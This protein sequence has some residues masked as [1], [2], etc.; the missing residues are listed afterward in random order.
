[1]AIRIPIVSEWDGRGLAKARRDIRQAEGFLGK[2]GA[3]AR[4]FKGT[5]IAAGTVAAGAFAKFSADAVMLASD[6]D[7]TKNKLNE[8]FGTG[9]GSLQ[10][11]LKN[12]ARSL[13][14]TRQQ[15][16]D[17][18]AT[19]GIFG[20]AAGL[21]GDD[22]VTFSEDLVR[23]SADFASFY[24]TSPED[25]ITA[26]GAALRSEAEPIRKY[27][28]LLDAA[29]LK[30]RALALGI[31]EGNEPLTAQQK[32]LAAQAEIF[33]QAGDAAGDFDRTQGGL[34]NSI[35]Q[36]KALFAELQTYFG[37]GLYD[38]L[39][40]NSDGL[41]TMEDS[42]EGL[43]DTALDVGRWFGEALQGFGEAAKDLQVAVEE[44]ENFADTM[45]LLFFPTWKARGALSGT[46]AAAIEA[47][48]AMAKA[49]GD[50]NTLAGALD[51]VTD[52]APK[53]SSA[54]YAAFGQLRKT[55]ASR[56]RREAEKLGSTLGGGGG[57]NSKLEENAEAA[58]RAEKA[59]KKYSDAVEIQ[60][61]RLE[62][63]QDELDEAKARFD[64]FASAGSSF[65]QAGASI[66]DAVKIDE[67]A[68]KAAKESGEEYA[69]T[70]YDAFTNAI[71]LRKEAAHAISVLQDSLNAADTRGNELLLE[72]LF[73]MDPAVAN[74][75]AR[76]M[77]ADG[78]GP[79][80]AAQLSSF[81]LF[82]GEAGNSW[83]DQFYGEGVRGAENQVA[84]IVAT[85][86][87][88]L[89][90]FRK[91]GR[92][93]GKAVMD[94]YNSVVAGLPVNVATPSTRDARSGSVVN[95]T[96][97]AG[98]GDPIAIARQVEATLRTA[99]TRTGVMR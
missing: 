92:K 31:S 77:I 47:G 64:E 86:E 37:E 73:A 84:G 3:A 40:A 95:V 56:A 38:G 12:S 44:G 90:E 91:A 19:F 10:A 89:E 26:I 82:A 2:A 94:G 79:A 11:N 43:G 78:T 32:I 57:T 33:A 71:Q 13:G 81:D 51:N 28:V 54:F 35:R 80:I 6:L 85:L 99:S 98:I 66:A 76:Q 62:K 45:R 58:E 46:V 69:G 49:A 74:E 48:N 17:A 53:P 96:V 9:S 8:V 4:A 75:I 72:Q 20:K 30:N 88:K 55:D 61:D 83:A 34:A 18:A 25:A 39:M 15:A 70:W 93:M 23:L 1:M 42:L 16:Y 22:L 14:Q 65:L 87:S 36:N 63:A 29:T 52:S 5:L 97:Q 41:D 59:I 67:N 50:A 7:E 24:N 21:A 68:R 27:G 60:V